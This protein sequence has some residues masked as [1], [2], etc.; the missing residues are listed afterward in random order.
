M[1]CIKHAELLPS[2]LPSLPNIMPQ[3]HG[4][5]MGEKL[6]ELSYVVLLRRGPPLTEK[7]SKGHHVTHEEGSAT[8][9]YNL[10]DSSHTPQQHISILH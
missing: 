7:V 2:H 4:T 6:K 3:T 5:D 10:P 8:L 1:A 9:L